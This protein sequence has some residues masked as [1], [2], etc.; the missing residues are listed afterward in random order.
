M[1]ILDGESI[2]SATDIIRFVAC[3]HLK[4]LELAA[5]RGEITRPRRVDPLLESSC[6][7]GMRTRKDCLPA[8]RR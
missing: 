5:T 4:Q 7:R 6:G 1:R 3:E 2:F 8:P